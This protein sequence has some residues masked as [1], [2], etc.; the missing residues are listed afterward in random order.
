MA[1][2]VHRQVHTVL[3]LVGCIL[4]DNSKVHRQVHTVLVLV[5]C[6]LLDNSNVVLTF[7]SHGKANTVAA[8][9]FSYVNI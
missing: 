9:R 8:T 7:E 1:R 5:G 6:I 2:Q 4:P 3:V